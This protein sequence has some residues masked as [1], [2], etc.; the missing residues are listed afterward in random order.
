MACTPAVFVTH[1]AVSLMTVQ[2]TSLIIHVTHSL[3]KSLTND[4]VKRLE[5]KHLMSVSCVTSAISIELMQEVALDC[6]WT[7][8][9]LSVS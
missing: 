5:E 3:S 9:N 4:Q 2:S 6:V 1:W 7:G 8:D